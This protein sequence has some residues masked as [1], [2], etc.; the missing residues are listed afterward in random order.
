M[1]NLLPGQQ[2]ING[3]SSYLFGSNMAQEGWADHTIRNNAQMQA[4][5]KQAGITLM[6]CSIVAGSSDA[7]IDQTAAACQAMGTAMIVILDH[8]NLSWNQHLVGYLGNRC[9]LYEFSNEPDLGGISWQ[10]YL[11]F[12]N[13]HIPAL[14]ALNA[15]AAFIGPALGVFANL[16]TYLVP[17]L[18][19]CQSSGVLPDAISYH[20]Y[21]CT[22][23]YTASTC[24]PRATS[25]QSAAQKVDAAV[26][27]VLGHT[28]PQALTE[29]NIDAANPV[30][31]FALDPSFV[32]TWTK[33][34]LDSMAAAGIAIACQWDA[35]S[36]AGGPGINNISGADD[37][38]NV[39]TLQPNGNGQYGAMVD[40]IQ[41]YK[42]GT[43][44]P[45]PTPTPTPTPTV[46][47]VRQAVIDF[48]AALKK[49]GVL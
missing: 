2:L 34:A 49:E 48:I 27:G 25:F 28:L 17:W 8:G 1:A 45:V 9:N 5:I 36:G 18:Q 39:V 35:G 29:W 33:Q 40:R 37:L 38:I 12:W 47:P 6:R 4:L 23:N 41:Y 43:P 46:D 44:T 16:Q 26:S 3:V 7:F 31:S 42:S 32:P 20:I 15:N 22:G 14:R 13:Q 19:G 30:H 24:A 11:S 10:S 21:P